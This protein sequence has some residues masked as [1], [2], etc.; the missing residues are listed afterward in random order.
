MSMILK[1]E[2]NVS[3]TQALVE[4]QFEYYWTSFVS[5]APGA[6]AAV[7][8]AATKDH[9][10]M[11]ASLLQDPAPVRTVALQSAV[12]FLSQQFGQR[13]VVEQIALRPVHAVTAAYLY[14]QRV[15]DDSGLAAEEP[16]YK[17]YAYLAAL[18]A[19]AIPIAEQSY[20]RFAQ[21][22]GETDLSEQDQ[23]VLRMIRKVSLSEPTSQPVAAAL[24]IWSLTRDKKVADGIE[25]MLGFA[26]QMAT[27]I[28]DVNPPAENASIIDDLGNRV[29]STYEAGFTAADKAELDAA[30]PGGELYTKVKALADAIPQ[31]L[32]D[33]ASAAAGIGTAKD[34]AEKLN[35][36]SPAVRSVRLNIDLDPND[37][38]PVATVKF[39]LEE[40]CRQRSLLLSPDVKVVVNNPGRYTVEGWDRIVARFKEGGLNIDLA[41]IAESS[42]EIDRDFVDDS[43][44]ER[45]HDEDDIPGTGGDEDVA[46]TIAHGSD[47]EREEFARFVAAHPESDADVP[48]SSQG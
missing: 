31:E 3:R 40:Y 9:L 4:N 26:S 19:A 46:E 32:C 30:A 11:L 35:A 7:L 24:N 14:H 48:V 18:A 44:L 20:D 29:E 22:I 8:A 23:A 47:A 37:P 16:L 2:F 17:V 25:T 1:P 15:L 43:G 21:L 6:A 45:E 39:M 5:T 33:A 12:L 41:P 38:D 34:L 27:V 13:F 42:E 28:N 36:E 10:Q